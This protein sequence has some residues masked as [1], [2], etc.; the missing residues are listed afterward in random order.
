MPFSVRLD[1]ETEAAIARLAR[2]TGKSRASVVREAVTRYAADAD[3]TET[4]YDRLTPLCGLVH[5]GR[6]VVGQQTGRKGADV[7]RK[8]RTDRARRTR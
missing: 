8:R 6:G 7:L 4:A 2:V 3:D 5:S 1:P